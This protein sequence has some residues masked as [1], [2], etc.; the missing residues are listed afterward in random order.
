VIISLAKSP[1]EL[2]ATIRKNNN[3]HQP[4]IEEG[5]LILNS[6]LKK[7]FIRLTRAR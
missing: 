3:V 2:S 6:P 4:A 5:I 1:K 7:L